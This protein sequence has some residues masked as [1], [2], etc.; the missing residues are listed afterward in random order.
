MKF[1]VVLDRFEII[2]RWKGFGGRAQVGCS[3]R[4]QEDQ[5]SGIQVSQ[6]ATARHAR[7][8]GAARLPWIL[9]FLQAARA[10]DLIMVSKFLHV[11]SVCIPSNPILEPAA[12]KVMCANGELLY[13][14]LGCEWI[15]LQA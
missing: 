10:A 13:P 8:A 1:V 4:L 12:K 7:T 6:R 5:N 11:A 2:F 9:V 3:R 14:R 15:L